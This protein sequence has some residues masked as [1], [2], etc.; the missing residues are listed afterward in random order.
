MAKQKS[1]P[2][3]NTFAE[4]LCTL[5]YRFSLSKVFDDFLTMAIAGCTQNPLTKL[6]YYEDEYLETIAYYKDSELRHEFPKAFAALIVEMEGRVTSSLGNDVLGEFFEQNIS[7]G[8][9]GQFFTPY[10]ICILMASITNTEKVSDEPFR[11]LDP[12]CGSGRMLLAAHDRNGSGHEYYGIDIDRSCVKMA[13]LNLFLNGMWNSE[14][15]CANALAPDDFVISYRISFL[16]LGIFKITEKEKSKLWVMHK[17]SF[18]LSEKKE[19]ISSN[20][21]LDKTP[22]SKRTKDN[23]TQLDLF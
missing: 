18:P 21:I 4:I 22:F 19:P 13:A 14:V 9:N 15:M 5:G 17:N 10:P 3:Q 23:S 16:P 8:R 7:N 6:S 2:S 20:I 1:V 11:I 12:A